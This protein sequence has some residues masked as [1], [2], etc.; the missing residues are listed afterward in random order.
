MNADDEEPGITDTE[1]DDPDEIDPGQ[2]SMFGDEVTSWWD[3]W[4]GMPEFQQNSIEPMQ[5]IKVHFATLDDLS[6]FA[7]LIEQQLTPNTKS[8]WYPEADIMTFTNR[9][10]G[11][12]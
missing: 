9:R 2:T 11:D 10:Y 8:I 3:D 4:Q 6:A 7:K 1:D 5:T 12:E